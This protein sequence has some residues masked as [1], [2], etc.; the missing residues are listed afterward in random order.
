M[1]LF[2]FS[3]FFSGWVLLVIQ[4]SQMPFKKN[5]IIERGRESDYIAEGGVRR[6]RVPGRCQGN[7]GPFVTWWL[8]V[9][10][11]D[12]ATSFVARAKGRATGRRT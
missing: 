1:S 11:S 2:Y 4:P 9:L 7:G 5:E 12:K 3:A 8:A 10:Y 6:I